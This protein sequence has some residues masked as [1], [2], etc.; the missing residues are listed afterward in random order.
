MTKL[1]WE[2]LNKDSKAQSVR[3]QEHFANSANA[4]YYMF[5]ASELWAIK[6][7]HY[8]HPIKALP[9]WYLDWAIDNITG[10]H[11][12]IAEKELRRRYHLSNT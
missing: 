3:D 6:G 12:D 8:G 9:L 4:D 7:K 1:N 2:R 10:I 5:L 11:R